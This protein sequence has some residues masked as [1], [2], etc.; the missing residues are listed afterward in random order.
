MGDLSVLL[1]GIR[2]RLDRPMRWVERRSK[3]LYP[4]DKKRQISHT[5]LRQLES[6]E[7][8]QPNPTK[9]QTLASIYNVDYGELMTAA[10]YAEQQ[11]TGNWDDIG[12]DQS[13]IELIKKML[14]RLREH[15]IRPAYFLNS[16]IGLTDES[17]S[18]VHRLITTMGIQGRK[19]KEMENR[20]ENT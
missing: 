9:L 10:G 14:A 1:K 6:G 19:K 7:H 4:E 13:E 2:Q 11:G 17:L 16:I 20:E 18:I 8:A 3:E 12:L 5:Y 15:N